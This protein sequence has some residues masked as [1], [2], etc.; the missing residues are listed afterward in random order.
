[1]HAYKLSIINE[2]QI[3]ELPEAN[4][5]IAQLGMISIVLLIVTL[6]IIIKH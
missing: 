3:A 6:P 5:E 2:H 1:M 4:Q